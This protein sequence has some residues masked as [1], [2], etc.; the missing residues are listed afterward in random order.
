MIAGGFWDCISANV[1]HPLFSSLCTDCLPACN[2][3]PLKHGWSILFGLQTE[4]TTFL[5]PKILPTDSAFI[6][7]RTQR[8]YNRDGETEIVHDSIHFVSVNK[9]TKKQ[10]PTMLHPFLL[11][12]L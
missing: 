1:L 3:N 12:I 7:I 4:T 2:Y 10:C 8:L 11:S 9:Q 6:Y 5:V